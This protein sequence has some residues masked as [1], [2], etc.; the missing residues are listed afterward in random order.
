MFKILIGEDGKYIKYI[1]KMMLSD[2]I[3]R[4]NK[5]NWAY[6]LVVKDLLSRMGFREVWMNQGVGNIE[7]FFFKVFKQRI[8]DNFLQNWNEG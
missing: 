4:L 8:T 1:Y 6:L 7:L 5:A 2:L 3:E